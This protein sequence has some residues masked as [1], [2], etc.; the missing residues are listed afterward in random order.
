MLSMFSPRWRRRIRWAVVL[1]IMLYFASNL[2]EV[3]LMVMLVDAIGLDVLLM[4]F[5]AQILSTYA[6]V[7]VPMLRGLRYAVLAPA[8]QWLGAGTRRWPLCRGV[9]AWISRRLRQASAGR[10]LWLHL[11]VLWWALVRRT[12]A[13]ARTWVSTPMTEPSCT[14]HLPAPRV[15]AT[16]AATFCSLPGS[17]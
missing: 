13:S 11:H 4:L 2:A 12:A 6:D 3:R 15:A 8:L 9:R 10:H 7:L 1:L 14:R 5:G 16:V 17:T